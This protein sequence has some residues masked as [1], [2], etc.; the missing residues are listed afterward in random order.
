MYLNLCTRRRNKKTP[1]LRGVFSSLFNGSF[2]VFTGFGV[3]DDFVA[4]VDEERYIEHRA[5]VEFDLLGAA[6]G[7][8]PSDAGRCLDDL[9]L[10]LDRE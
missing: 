1:Q 6:G 2:N 7:S 9:E 10:H 8:V 3:D 4:L 5:G